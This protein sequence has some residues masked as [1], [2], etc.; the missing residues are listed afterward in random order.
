MSVRERHGVETSARPARPSPRIP[1]EVDVS[2]A[3]AIPAPDARR[4]FR[5]AWFAYL[6]LVTFPLA[7]FVGVLWSIVGAGG[8]RGLPRAADPWFLSTMA[9]LAVAVPAAL[10]VRARLCAAYARGDPVAPGRYLLGMSAVWASLE[11]GMILALAGCYATGSFLPGLVPAVVAFVFLAAL[12]PNGEM[13]T[14]RAG[15]T[16]DPDGH[17]QPR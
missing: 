1:Q 17:E 16:E 13:L 11:V 3:L 6:A 5:A 8:T 10:F 9:Y 14:G 4:A 15:A 7:L 2:T 12:W